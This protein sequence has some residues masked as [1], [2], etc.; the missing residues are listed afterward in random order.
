MRAFHLRP[1]FYARD[2]RLNIFGIVP[3]LFMA[4]FTSEP[5]FIDV[6]RENFH[7]N[8]R[9]VWEP[10]FFSSL[11]RN[12]RYFAVILFP[13]IKLTSLRISTVNRRLNPPAS[14]PSEFHQERIERTCASFFPRRGKRKKKEGKQRCRTLFERGLDSPWFLPRG[15]WFCSKRRSPLSWKALVYREFECSLLTRL[16]EGTEWA[17][18]RDRCIRQQEA[19]ICAGLRTWRNV[20]RSL[21]GTISRNR[22]IELARTV[23]FIAPTPYHFAAEKLAFFIFTSLT[24]YRGSWRLNIV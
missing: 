10:L 16:S 13:L 1:L 9:F 24:N 5:D 8:N 12:T 20:A 3:I 11:F 6:L 14:M 21:R 7:E 4:L 2:K 18:T 15:K 22:C 19:P 17:D 23:R